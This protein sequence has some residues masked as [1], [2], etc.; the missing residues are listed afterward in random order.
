M[1]VIFLLNTD[2]YK[3]KMKFGSEMAS[4]GMTFFY[5]NWHVSTKAL[6]F[7]SDTQVLYSQTIIC[8]K[9]SCSR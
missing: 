7:V 1:P 8:L 3:L 6:F 5:E 9:V 4:I 2:S